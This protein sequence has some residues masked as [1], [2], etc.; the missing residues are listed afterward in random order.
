[1]YIEDTQMSNRFDDL[2]KSTYRPGTGR[3]GKAPWWP[4]WYRCRESWSAPVA[5]AA[6][7]L[8]CTFECISY[9]PR[10]P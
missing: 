1:L 8:S 2:G 4:C 7:N 5:S 6:C 9:L 10:D 3:L